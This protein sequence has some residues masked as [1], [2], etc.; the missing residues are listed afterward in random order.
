MQQITVEDLEIQDNYIVVKDDVEYSSTTLPPLELLWNE[1]PTAEWSTN[2]FKML[3]GVKRKKTVYEED[4]TPVVTTVNPNEDQDDE[5]DE[6]ED[7][8]DDVPDDDE[9]E[10]QDDDDD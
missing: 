1:W 7:D 5:D 9:D 3:F 10:D 8:E 4:E 2:L 6:Q